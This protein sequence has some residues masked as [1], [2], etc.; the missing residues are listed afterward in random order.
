M[1]LT[2]TPGNTVPDMDAVGNV[3]NDGKTYRPSADEKKIIE[4]TMYR[5]E[6][7]ML[8]A[9]QP[10]HKEWDD[11]K[12]IYESEIV[13][14]P[15]KES[16]KVNL[17]HLV[18]DAG[19]SEEIDAFPD[20]TIDIQEPGDKQKVP[21]LNA[22]KK[23]ALARANWDKVKMNA[24]RV[25]RI[26]GICPVRIS[27]E[28]TTRKI[29][30][31]VPIK[32]D[33]GMKLSFREKIDHPKDDIIMEVIDNPRR[34][35][36][37]DNSYDL[38]ENT[39]DCALIT[40]VNWSAFQQKVQHDIR[41]KNIQ[42]V[43][44]GH[45]YRFDKDGAE[46]APNQNMQET[47]NKKVRLIEYWNRDLDVYYIFANGVLIYEGCLDD[48]KE[49]PFAVLHMYRRPHS[50]YSK[51]IPKLI[52]S[53]EAAYN[54]VMRAEVRATKLAFPVLATEEDANLDPRQVMGYPG[55][56]LEGG[57][58]RVEL[59]QLGSV[60]GEVYKL[61]DKIEELLIW[62]TGV[63]FKQIYG[64]QSDRV[65]IEA[66]K[67]ESMLA[68]VNANLRENEAN[69]VVRLGGLLIK[70]I[71]QHYPVPT[72]KRLAGDE[73]TKQY[74]AKELIKDETGK[75]VAVYQYRKIP[76]E[77]MNLKEKIDESKG[78][79]S[80]SNEGS[81]DSYILARPEYIRTQSHL[82]IRPIRPS[83]MGSSKEAKKL[84]FI[85][86]SDHAIAVNQAAMTMGATQGPPGPDG[87]PAQ[88]PGKPIWNLEYLQ[89]KLAEAHELP[90]E[91]V[92]MSKSKDEEESAVSRVE[93]IGNA[94]NSS[95]FTPPSGP[96]P[97]QPAGSFPMQGMGPAQNLNPE[98]QQQ[99]RQLIT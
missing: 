78:V 42:F 82:D 32:G 38:D 44:P 85:E 8:A 47:M 34:F 65:G 36:I 75:A 53:L 93:K 50:F 27:Y 18:I 14:D 66:L 41:Y 21:L 58:D 62:T 67:K 92:I 95:F 24:L 97:G 20:I 5:I 51:G 31:R 86:L 90:V 72:I 35:L 1:E 76:V 15:L 52:E 49:L 63:N 71:M 73:D 69:F 96:T 33:D 70:L 19:M 88:Q 74:R 99:F 12:K 84:T 46:V 26:Y 39:T 4:E 68:R 17:S 55:V 30:E 48:H 98:E 11:A 40:D 29:K 10:F 2:F 9:Q 94:F 79:F 28:R 60:P 64:E 57:K 81:E 77:G 56:L 3:P 43:R 87:M 7:E 22:A 45:D 37:D 89:E 59:M 25:R 23:Y 16:F 80:L 91:K 61:K 6:Y 54:S 83:A 13:P